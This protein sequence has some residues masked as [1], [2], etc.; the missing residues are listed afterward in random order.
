[1][2]FL[3]PRW[4]K[5]LR[6]LWSNKTRTILVLLSISV[7]VSAIGMVMGSQIMVDQNLPAAY[8]AVNPSNAVMFSLDTFGDDMIESIRASLPELPEEK[9]KRFIEQYELKP[10]DER[11]M[12]S[13]KALAGFFES[14]V[15]Q[16]KSPARTVSTWITGEFMRYLNDSG[17]SIE[18]ITL[19]PES[20]A[21]LIDMTTDK[22]ISGNSAKV[23][24]SEMVKTS[25]DPEKPRPPTRVRVRN[26]ILAPLRNSTA[27]NPFVRRTCRT[28]ADSHS[29]ASSRSSIRRNASRPVSAWWALCTISRSPSSSA[30]TSSRISRMPF[31]P[32]CLGAHTA[33]ENAAHRSP[34]RSSETRSTSSCH[35]SS[36]VPVAA[37][38]STTSGQSG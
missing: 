8:A 2:I 35:G 14:V 5:V 15:A 24:F 25:G 12:T 22:V 27:S 3:A 13:E 26:R 9:T 10:Q 33:T 4:R 29:F 1:M 16:S 21:K 11:L 36:L 32:F 7:G 23:V 31:L 20:F 19:S 28:S 37:T 30:P 18:H 34:R 38:N 17:A 6:D